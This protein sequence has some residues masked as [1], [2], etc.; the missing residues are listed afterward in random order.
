MKERLELKVGMEG[1]RKRRKER[2]TGMEEKKGW[3]EGWTG[4]EGRT[5]CMFC[6]GALDHHG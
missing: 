1:R 6:I 2:Q 5:E 3:T 4:L